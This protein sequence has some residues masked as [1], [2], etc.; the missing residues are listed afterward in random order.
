[1]NAWQGKTNAVGLV[2]IRSDWGP[3]KV[4]AALDEVWQTGSVPILSYDLQVTN[5]AV[6]DGAIDRTVDA[7]AAG[8][9]GWLA[10]PDSVYGNGD[11]RRAYLRPAW[12]MNGNWYR[13]SPCNA[14]GSTVEEFKAMWRH[15]HGR[16]ATAGI[17]NTHLAWIYSANVGDWSA[18]CTAEALYPGDSFVDWTGVDGY[19]FTSTKSAYGVFAPMIERLRALAPSKPIS[20]NEWGADSLTSVGKST[21]I[22]GFFLVA[23]YFDVRM[24][25]VF[26]K[27][28]ER[29]WAVFGGGNGDGAFDH[30]GVSFKAWN[31]YRAGVAD[32]RVIGA[33]AT[34]PRR[35]TDAQ[36]LGQ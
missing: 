18:A 8:M 9:K 11:D 31:T 12:E 1:M 14:A 28:K 6:V 5:R 29:D 13:W 17:D 7:V 15:L 2:F 21:W 16:F 26:N 32:E 4:I 10:G 34:N 33:D 23:H 36:F 35:I 30:G 22:T 25:V 27:D 20:I 19:T 3:V 24:S